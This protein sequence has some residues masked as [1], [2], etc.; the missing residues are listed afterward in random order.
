MLWFIYTVNFALMLLN[1]LNV[2]T[3]APELIYELSFLKAKIPRNSGQLKSGSQ[4]AIPRSALCRW[5]LECCLFR[6]AGSRLLS[7]PFGPRGSALPSPSPFPLS[8]FGLES[9]L[10]PFIHG[11]LPG[12]PPGIFPSWNYSWNPSFLPS[13]NYPWNPSWNPSQNSSFVKSLLPGIFPGIVL[14][15]LPG[16]LPSLF[17]SQNPSWHSSYL[18]SFWESFLL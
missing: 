6:G 12:I 1:V 17:P 7:V 5:I 4:E 14:Y 2:I 9:F 3:G 13:W 10:E 18:E 11:I 16:I 15:F 8:S